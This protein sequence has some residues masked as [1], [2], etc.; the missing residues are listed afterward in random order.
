MEKYEIEDKILSLYYHLEVMW[1]IHSKFEGMN[2]KEATLYRVG[3]QTHLLEAI[4]E[5]KEVLD[6][7][8]VEVESED[9]ML[10]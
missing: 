2:R 1:A 6:G 4:K 9:D 8:E 5:A 10:Q 7:L 3:I